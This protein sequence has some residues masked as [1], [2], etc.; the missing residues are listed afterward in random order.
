[1]KKIVLLAACLLTSL[2]VL[3]AQNNPYNYQDPKLWEEEVP[4]AAFY[5]GENALFLGG[6]L[7]NAGSDA[8]RSPGF[9]VRSAYLEYTR[10]FRRNWYWGVSFSHNDKVKYTIPEMKDDMFDKLNINVTSLH[11]MV[12]YRLPVISTQLSLRMGLGL[13]FGYNDVTYNEFDPDVKSKVMPYITAEVQWIY[14]IGETVEIKFSPIIASPSRLRFSPIGMGGAA[15]KVFSYYDL[16]HLS[17]G[18]VF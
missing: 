8:S 11:G 4:R 9:R 1:M 14:R 17:F 10:S 18:Y 2:G 16:F 13:G 5:P 6:D 3:S 7:L 12:Y 15:P